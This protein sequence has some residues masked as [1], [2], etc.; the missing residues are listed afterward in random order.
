MNNTIRAQINFSF[1]GETYDLDTVIDLDRCSGNTD[2][3]PNFHRDLALA[4][5]IDTYSYLYEMLESYDITFSDATGL[6]APYCQDGRFDWFEFEK[7]RREEC[8][9]DRV[10]SIVQST[11]GSRDLD[12]DPL[13]KSALLAV[14]NAGKTSAH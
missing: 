12:A 5:N 6:A 8:D 11:L 1:K 2:E 9:W 13:L 14:F 4:G 7:A 3:M 10:C